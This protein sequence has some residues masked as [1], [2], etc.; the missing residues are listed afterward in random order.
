[1]PKAYTI[2]KCSNC[3]ED[4]R[5][6]SCNSQLFKCWWSIWPIACRK[7]KWPR[8]MNKWLSSLLFYSSNCS[9]VQIQNPNRLTLTLPVL[10][11]KRNCSWCTMKNKYSIP[12]TIWVKTSP[13]NWIKSF[14]CTSL[15]FNTKYLRILRLSKYSSPRRRNRRPTKRYRRKCKSSRILGSSCGVL[16]RPS[17]VPRFRWRDQTV[18]GRCSRTSTRRASMWLTSENINEES[19]H[20]QVERRLR[21]SSRH[22]S[23]WYRSSRWS[24]RTETC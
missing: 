24:K 12:S 23:R 16:G 11:Y 7:N 20:G 9:K 21:T 5:K 3:S 1:M 14:V 4:I 8:S 10:T 18:R 15:R 13:V 2:M 22:K 6:H 17:L 19:G